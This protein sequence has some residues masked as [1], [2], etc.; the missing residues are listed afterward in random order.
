MGATTF[1]KLLSGLL[2]PTTGRLEILGREMSKRSN[3]ATSK[4]LESQSLF[5]PT[6]EPE[7]AAPIQY[8]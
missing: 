7:R 8:L 6:E 2:K 5:I 3:F 1:L 4:G